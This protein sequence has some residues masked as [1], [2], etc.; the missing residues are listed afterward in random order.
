MSCLKTMQLIAR[1]NDASVPST[2]TVITEKL[3][4]SLDSR[5]SIVLATIESIGVFSKDDDRVKEH[6]SSPEVLN[7]HRL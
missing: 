5:F 1:D 4:F 3:D 7:L 6:L 2:M